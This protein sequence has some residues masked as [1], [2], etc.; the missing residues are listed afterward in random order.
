[1]H[2]FATMWRGNIRNRMKT[3]YLGYLYADHVDLYQT[4]HV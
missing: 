3:D 4:L 2:D 1:M